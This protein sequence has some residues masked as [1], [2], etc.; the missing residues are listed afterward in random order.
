MKKFRILLLALALAL[1]FC[2]CGEK[3]E[4]EEVTTAETSETESVELTPT[5]ASTELGSGRFETFEAAFTGAETFAGADG[6]EVLRV[7]FDFTNCSDETV[8]A[9]DR[10]LISAVQDGKTL[11][12]AETENAGADN[13]ALRLQPGHKIRCT[14]DYKL[15][16]SSPVAILLDDAEGHTVSA[17]L[18]LDQ[19]PGA[20]EDEA[21]AEPSAEETTTQLAAQCDLFGLYNITITGGTVDESGRVMT[22]SVDFTNH[23]DP[24]EADIWSCIRMFAYQD[25]VELTFVEPEEE[26]IELAALGQTITTSNSFELRGEGPVLVELYG[27][28]ETEPCA[29]LVIPIA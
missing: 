8:S 28:R 13:S 22:V 6:S 12:W 9:Q 19:L 2:A 23:S 20:P 1:A 5:P 15:V 21:S 29:G 3:N 26:T 16:S 25:G 24:Q 7:Y 17:L 10:L 14:L 27:F 11:V 4:P 18:P